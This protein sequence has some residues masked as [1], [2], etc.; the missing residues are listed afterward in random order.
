MNKVV[1]ARLPVRVAL[2]VVFALLASVA[3]MP[4]ASG[5]G[6]EAVSHNIAGN[7]KHGGSS[8]AWW[9]ANALAATSS[10]EWVFGAQEVCEIQALWQLN[11]LRVNLG[12]DW[13]GAFRSQSSASWICAAGAGTANY[14][15]AMFGRSSTPGPSVPTFPAG[16]ILVGTFPHQKPYDES[17]GYLCVVLSGFGVYLA[18]TAHMAPGNDTPPGSSE[19]YRIHQTRNYLTR[20]ALESISGRYTRVW[21]TGDFYATPTEIVGIDP[22]LGNWSREGDTCDGA[23]NFLA[24]QATFDG[25]GFQGIYDYIFLTKPVQCQGDMFLVPT[26][27]PST[28]WYDEMPVP[29]NW[30]HRA[31]GADMTP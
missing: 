2:A 29:Y 30:D 5:A 14:G 26:G 3:V 18:C 11:Y 12:S 27:N 20:V 22:N 15:L 7:M 23:A 8:S 9:L 17:R 28:P 10:D 16:Q 1:S 31:L 21:W 19:P 4:V 24:K 6:V 13:H 25:A